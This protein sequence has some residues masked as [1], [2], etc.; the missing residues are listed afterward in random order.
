MDKPSP[1][2]G[3]IRNCAYAQKRLE[4]TQAAHSFWVNRGCV[5]EDVTELYEKQK[6]MEN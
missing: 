1:Y 4:E 2:P 5:Y 3:L 6:L